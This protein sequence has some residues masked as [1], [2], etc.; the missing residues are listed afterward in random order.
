MR[1]CAHFCSMKASFWPHEVT[2]KLKHTCLQAA[3]THLIRGLAREARARKCF[4]QQLSQRGYVIVAL[5]G[6][7]V[8]SHIRQS[9]GA[10]AGVKVQWLNTNQSLIWFVYQDN[11]S[12]SRAEVSNVATDHYNI[13]RF[14]NCHNATV[15]QL[16][17]SESR[18]SAAALAFVHSNFSDSDNTLTGLVLTDSHFTNLSGR[19]V[20]IFNSTAAIYSTVFDSVNA[21][22]NRSTIVVNNT[23]VATFIMVDCNLTNNWPATTLQ[24]SSAVIQVTSS[25]FANNNCT[26]GGP[27]TIE[28]SRDASGHFQDDNVAISSS[29]FQNNWAGVNA[30]GVAMQGSSGQ[31]S[32]KLTVS[33]SLFKNNI[34]KAES[35]Q[36]GGVSTWGVFLI[37]I[38]RCDFTGNEGAY[39]PADMYVYG[40]LERYSNIVVANSSFTNASFTGGGCSVLL[41]SCACVGVEYSSFANSNSQ[42]LCVHDVSGTCEHTF[43]G[44]AVGTLFDRS[45]IADNRAQNAEIASWFGEDASID[46]SVDIRRSNFSNLTP[47]LTSSTDVF[48][49]HAGLSIWQCPYV[50]LTEVRAEN[51]VARMG[52]VLLDEFDAAV[53]WNSTFDSNIAAYAGGG[54]ASVRSSGAGVLVAS[55]AAYN[56]S[57]LNGGA[58]YGNQGLNMRVVDSLLSN[59]TAVVSGGAVYGDA[60]Q[61]IY[62]SNTTVVGNTAGEVG[63]GLYSDSSVLV[64]IYGSQ[65]MQNR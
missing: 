32:E 17:V 48:R 39:G 4:C 50:L 12:L 63:G 35:Q 44:N 11:I 3:A 58:L 49:S 13:L 41:W 43:T 62:L 15:S 34:A 25:V 18:S 24:L 7:A 56:N 64:T 29:T 23:G 21:G 10:R 33:D 5:Y 46:I 16:V 31:A 61:H 55:C 54:L 8:G 26:D 40:K 14:S 47:H 45:S 6:S 57:A 38:E 1:V 60:T 52:G 51:I 30:G 20:Q 2:R 65:L 36:P 9:S 28:P 53:V 22:S 19:A 42:G 59:N 37:S 27:V